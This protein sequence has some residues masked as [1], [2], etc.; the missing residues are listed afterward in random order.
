MVPLQEDHPFLP[1][2]ADAA[3][4]LESACE[5]R[6]HVA[7]DLRV[8]AFD[9][10]HLLA[11]AGFLVAGNVEQTGAIDSFGFGG[12]G[13]QIGPFPAHRLVQS[14]QGL[15]PPEFAHAITAFA[16]GP[17]ITPAPSRISVNCKALNQPTMSARLCLALVAL[18]SFVSTRLDAQ[19]NEY[20]LMLL[21]DSADMVNVAVTEI[22]LDCAFVPNPEECFT[23]AA[24]LALPTMST[25]CISC[26]GEQS[27]CALSNCTFACAFGTP[28]AC[29]ECVSNNC[30]AA[31]EECAGI[32]DLDED[33]HNNICDCDDNNPLQHPGA[34][35]T[36]EGIDNNCNGLMEASEILIEPI[37][38][39]GDFSGDLL[40]GAADLVIFLGQFSC[41]MNCG[42]EDLD[43]DGLVGVSDLVIFLGL[44]GTFC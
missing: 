4:R 42:E 34:A 38:C 28:E 37:A 16:H 21:C 8:E 39:E 35:G 5:I 24:L 11:L 14:G 30:Q 20:D 26:F 31:F 9:E 13:G 3:M 29:A 23:S 25:G 33:T 18:L 44:V 40:V 36:N 17:K 7:V 1:S 22:A 15:Q 43:Q 12:F 6:R 10:G 2:T 32:V 27:T 19:C 41:M